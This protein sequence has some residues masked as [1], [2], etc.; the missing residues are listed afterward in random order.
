ML[1]PLHPPRYLPLHTRPRLLLLALSLDIFGVHSFL[2][3]L[4][5]LRLAFSTLLLLSLGFLV[6]LGHLVEE[7]TIIDTTDGLLSQQT[8]FILREEPSRDPLELACKPGFTFKKTNVT[9]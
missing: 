6:L 2:R 5:R 1:R 3:A 8:V 9:T 7:G 4:Q